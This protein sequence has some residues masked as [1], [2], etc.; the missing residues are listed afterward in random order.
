M[1]HWW[2]L[3]SEWPCITQTLTPLS[4]GYTLNN[5]FWFCIQSKFNYIK[6]ILW[7]SWWNE[8]PSIGHLQI[9]RVCYWRMYLVSRNVWL[10]YSRCCHICRMCSSGWINLLWWTHWAVSLSNLCSTTAVTKSVVCAILSVGW[11]I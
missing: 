11:C 5:L 8:I 7:I 9:T 3:I 4:Y 2:G 6:S 10:I 1:F